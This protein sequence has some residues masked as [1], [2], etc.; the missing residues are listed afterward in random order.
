[1]CSNPAVAEP[2]TVTTKLEFPYT[3]SL[4]PIIGAFADGL[5]EGRLLASRSPSGRVMFP[6][7]EHDP[8]TSQSA[9]ADLVE[10]GPGATVR[11]WVWVAEPSGRHP[12]QQPFAFALVQPDG[13]DTTAVHVVLVD[14][15]EQMSTGM[16]VVPRWRDERQG[17]IDDIEGWV[18][19]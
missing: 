6:P 18:P 11:S 13:A 10:V 17:R 7:L 9:L 16:R 8:D 4:G 1:M 19:A 12:V 3:R 15:P 14:G 5:R 2:R